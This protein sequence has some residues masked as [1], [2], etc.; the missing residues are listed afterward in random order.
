MSGDSRLPDAMPSIRD[1]AYRLRSIL[2]HVDDGYLMS[3]RDCRNPFISFDLL[4]FVDDKNDNVAF[5]FASFE[6]AQI[7]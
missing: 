7:I 3:I 6:L 4:F 2:M 1:D 5:G